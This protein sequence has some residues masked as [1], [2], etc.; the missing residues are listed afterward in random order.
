MSGSPTQDSVLFSI[1]L[2][3]STLSLP[4]TQPHT[5]QEDRRRHKE[6]HGLP[7]PLSKGNGLKETVT[8]VSALPPAL[9]V[10]SPALVSLYHTL[11]ITAMSGPLSQRMPSSFSGATCSQG[12]ASRHCVSILDPGQGVRLAGLFESMLCRLS[13]YLRRWRSRSIRRPVLFSPPS[14]EKT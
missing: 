5:L 13:L 8:S 12:A 7:S 14:D 1:T 10:S 2:I 3:K 11:L 9:R 4:V 6:A